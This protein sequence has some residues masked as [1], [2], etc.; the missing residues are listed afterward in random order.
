MDAKKKENSSGFDVSN[1][2]SLLGGMT[3][4]ADKSTGLE[5][6]DIL[7]IVGSL[8]SNQTQNQGGASGMLGLLGKLFRK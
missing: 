5:L 1:I 4:K 8:T 7:S 2:A 3:Q 6:G